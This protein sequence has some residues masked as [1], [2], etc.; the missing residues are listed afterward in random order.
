VTVA[1][2]VVCGLGTPGVEPV[3]DDTSHATDTSRIQLAPGDEQSLTLLGPVN[4]PSG[5][6]VS[7]DCYPTGVPVPLHSGVISFRGIQVSAI[8][9]GTLE[10]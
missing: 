7:L 3:S 10:H 8:Q 1:Q 4:L 9:V 6:D 2:E 5:G